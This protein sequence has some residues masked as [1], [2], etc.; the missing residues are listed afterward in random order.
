LKYALTVIS[1]IGLICLASGCLDL[2]EAVNPDLDL[3]VLDVMA[4]NLSAESPRR[5][6]ENG[7]EYIYIK[8]NVTNKNDDLDHIFIAEKFKAED[9][10]RNPYDAVHLANLAE[11]ENTFTL[12]PEEGREFYVVFKV[13][14]D[15]ELILLVMEMGAD[16]DFTDDIPEYDHFSPA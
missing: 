4:S 7:T 8:V 1:I 16:E 3:E 2:E 11:R 13:P 14:T 5:V 9:D 10:M 15:V 12:K 6:A